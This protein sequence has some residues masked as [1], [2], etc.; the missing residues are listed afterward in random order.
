MISADG[1]EQ[2]ATCIDFGLRGARVRLSNA[3]ALKGKSVRFL[4]PAAE[5]DHAFDADT[6]WQSG[7]EVGLE[8]TG[9]PFDS[10]VY[11]R[12]VVLQS[13]GHSEAV[14]RDLGVDGAIDPSPK[15]GS[16]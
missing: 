12:N 15:S 4:V 14:G 11:A 10:F 16:K 8:F 7:S 3:I 13:S 1:V 5:E 2:P 6:V 9:V